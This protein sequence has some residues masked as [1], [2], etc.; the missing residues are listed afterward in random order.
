MIHLMKRFLQSFDTNELDAGDVTLVLKLLS[1]LEMSLWNR[2]S[3]SDQR[4]S[5]RVLDRFVTFLPEATTGERVGVV[6]HDVGKIDSGLGAFGRVAATILGPRTKR[7][8]SYHDHEAIGARL[9]RESGSNQ[10]AIYILESRGRPEAM[11][12]Y[13]RAD[14]Y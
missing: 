5:I 6:L 1:P 11:A 10:D 4:H 2:M 9:L 3:V 13:R 8:A 12:A 7:F 14:H